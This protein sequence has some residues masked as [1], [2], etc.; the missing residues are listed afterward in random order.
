MSADEQPVTDAETQPEP[1]TEA[2]DRDVAGLRAALFWIVAGLLALT[3]A[4]VVYLAQQI[5]NVRA[6]IDAQRRRIAEYH[7]LEPQ[8]KDLI[9]RLHS[10]A[11]THPDFQPIMAKY[12]P[13]P[14]NAAKTK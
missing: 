6:E 5:A 13:A 14:T 12:G 10:F 2:L 4:F 11:A 1:G 9:T 7:Q 3:A 8:V